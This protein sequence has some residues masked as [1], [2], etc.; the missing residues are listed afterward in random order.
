MALGFIENSKLQRPCLK[1]LKKYLKDQKISLY[2]GR[3]GFTDLMLSYGQKIEDISV[4]MGHTSI[5]VTWRY[6]KNKLKV[7]F[8]KPD[9]HYTWKQQSLFQISELAGTKS[10]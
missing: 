4:W 7:S 9:N 10:Y 2:G 6:Y 3:K 5:E 8:T 1:T